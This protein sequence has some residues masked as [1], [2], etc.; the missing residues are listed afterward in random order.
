MKRGAFMRTEAYKVTGMHC[1]GCVGSVKRVLERHIGVERAEVSL[2]QQVAEVI[3][4][5]DLVSSKEIIAMI[6]KLGYKVEV[7]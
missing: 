7:K 1:M 5:D 3:F 2:E 4:N 6:E